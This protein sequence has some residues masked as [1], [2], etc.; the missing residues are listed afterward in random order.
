MDVELF[1]SRSRSL[2]SS[3]ASPLVSESLFPVW[4]LVVISVYSCSLKEIVL[5]ET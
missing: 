2:C 5:L 1:Q 4:L 3:G